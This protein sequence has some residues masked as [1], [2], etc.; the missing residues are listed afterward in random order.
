MF[1]RDFV[2]DETNDHLISAGK[3]RR[4]YSAEKKHR[5]SVIP[6]SG[7]RPVV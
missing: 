4:R 5:V 6:E 1:Q 7:Q 3:Q 2:S